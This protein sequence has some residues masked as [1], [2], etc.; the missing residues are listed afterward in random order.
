MTSVPTAAPAVLH[1]Y[2]GANLATELWDSARQ[3]NGYR[4]QRREI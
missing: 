3:S 1:V 2:D 4:G